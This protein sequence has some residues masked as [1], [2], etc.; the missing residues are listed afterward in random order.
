M[1]AVNEIMKAHGVVDQDTKV[2]SQCL[3]SGILR[4]KVK[5]LKP[6]D[7]PE[8]QYG[9]DQVDTISNKCP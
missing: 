6:E 4:N 7:D 2:V 1:K 3:K 8:N 9:L 5:L